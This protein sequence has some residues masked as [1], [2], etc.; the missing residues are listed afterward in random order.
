MPANKARSVPCPRYVCAKLFHNVNWTFVIDP[1]R[2]EAATWAQRSAPAVCEDEGPTMIGP[3]I[4]NA[5]VRV[6]V[7]LGI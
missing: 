6:D 7:C 5:E 2:R 4:S 1:S 3:N